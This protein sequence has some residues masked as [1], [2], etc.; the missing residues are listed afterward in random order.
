MMNEIKIGIPI[1]SGE[2]WI[3]GVIYVEQLIKAIS[4]VSSKKKI[5]LIVTNETFYSFNLHKQLI[6]SLTGVIFMGEVTKEI[7]NHIVDFIY[8]RNIDELFSIIDFYFPSFIP[9]KNKCFAAWIPDFQHRYLPELFSKQMI[10]ARDQMFSDLAELSKVVVLSS[11][12]V[13][14]DFKKF[15]PDSQAITRVLHFHSLPVEEWYTVEPRNIQKKYNLP[16]N[17]IICCNQFWKHKNHELLFKAIAR[18]KKSHQNINLVCTGAKT[19]YRFQHYFSHLENVIRKNNIQDSVYI[20]GHIPRNDQI[21]LIR[22]SKF[23]IQPSLFEGWSTV[24]EDARTLG[25]PILLS[26]LTVNQEQSPKYGVYFKRNDLNDLINKIG[27]LANASQPGPNIERE[28]VAKME[29]LELIK[30]YAETFQTIANETIKIHNNSSELNIIPSIT[31]SQSTTVHIN[32][33]EHPL[34]SIITPSF[35]QSRFILETIQTVLQQDYLNVEHIVIDG[36]STDGTLEI[37]KTCSENDARFRFISEPDRGQSHAINKGLKIAKGEII[38]W[39]NSDDTYLPG[40]VSKVVEAFRNHPNLGVIYGNAYIT[41]EMNKV[42]RPYPTEKVSIESLFHSCSISQ[43]AAFIKKN[44]FQ[45]L[46]GVDENLQF[47]M[48]YDLWIRVAKSS[49]PLGYIEEFLANSRWHESSKTGSHL[50]DIGFPEIIKTNLKHF[51]SVSITW[52]NHFLEY[53][54]NQGVFWYLN[55]FKRFDI[56]GDSPKVQSSNRYSDLWAPPHF[57]VTIDTSKKFPLEKLLLKGNNMA[58]N[59][60]HLQAYMD[61]KLVNT[62]VIE[63]GDFL[64]DIPINSNQTRCTIEVKSKENMIPAVISNSSDTRSLSFLAEE[65]IPLSNLEEQFY[66]E[67]NKGPKYVVRWMSENFK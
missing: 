37:L 43:P 58:F 30:D 32:T 67:F 61:S 8:C 7:Q 23:L 6:P 65:I 27:Y 35:N 18:L 3:G 10:D 12:E 28:K 25:K 41:N 60:L 39:L 19:D 47:C 22:R 9:L 33:A 45:A 38:G 50:V 49:H 34:V 54:W 55:L 48:D 5:Y 21:Q 64:I 24:V 14:K 57:F 4:S 46:N 11:K 31:T 56:L 40:A 2:E 59:P 26:D 52:I 53:Y 66:E 16:D 44:V 51:G 20:L 63:H 62:Y 13:E 36:G 42:I 29:A 17:F 1:I 15:Y